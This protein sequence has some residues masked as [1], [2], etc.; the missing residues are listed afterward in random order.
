[1]D[2]GTER[3]NGGSETMTAIAYSDE[4]SLEGQGSDGG[5]VTQKARAAIDHLKTKI[6]KTKDLIRKEQDQKE[7]K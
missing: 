6:D 3:E 7:C 1:M 5:D 4:G 2:G